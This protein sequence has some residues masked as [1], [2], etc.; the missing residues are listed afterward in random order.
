MS[1]S[2]EFLVRHGSAVL[3]AAVLIE[4]KAPLAHA[5]GQYHTDRFDCPDFGMKPST[6]SLHSPWPMMSS[7]RSLR[8][9]CTLAG[10][11]FYTQ[12]GGRARRELLNG[13]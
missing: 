8:R 9:Y 13:R 7:W 5:V 1:N 6:A 2:L 10:Q 4:L 12:C 3:F 11:L